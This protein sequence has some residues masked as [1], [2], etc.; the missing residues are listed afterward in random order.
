[1][2]ADATA[3]GGAGGDGD[4]VSS[5]RSSGADRV[6]VVSRKVPAKTVTKDAARGAR[7]PVTRVETRLA[8]AGPVRTAVVGTGWGARVAVPALRA[9]GLVVTALVGRTADKA[10]AEA[11]RLGIGFATD[12]IADVLQRDDVDLVYVSTPPRT[13]EPY[14]SMILKA[15][16]HCLCEKPLALTVVRLR[17]MHRYSAASLTRRLHRMKQTRCVPQRLPQGQDVGWR[18]LTTSFAS[19]RSCSTCGSL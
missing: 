9:G 8:V 14:S 4:S 17:I 10:E 1:M 16:L 11:K 6:V 3:T 12:D 5:R 13:H 18:L 19:C 2:A 15:G 7:F